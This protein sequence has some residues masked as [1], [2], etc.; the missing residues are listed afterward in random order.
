MHAKGEL[1]EKMKPEA[2][3]VLNAD[4][5]RL[6]ALAERTS[7]QLILFGLSDRAAIRAVAVKE[8]ESGVG[9][10]L[11]LPTDRL[12]IVLKT[13]GIFMV[14]NA[15]AAAAVGHH[16]GLAPAEIKT[17]LE[18]FTP[19]PGR[20]NIITTREDIHIIDDTYNANPGSMEAAIR[21]LASLKG[22]DRGIFVAGDMLELG[23]QADR[24]HK[25]IGALSARC[26][27]ARLYATGEWA[28][29]VAAGARRE[30][31]NPRDIFV[32]SRREILADLKDRLR[33]GDW[34]LVKGSRSM[35]ME[36]I[37]KGLQ[38]WTEENSA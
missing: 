5:P 27:I 29:A 13:P 7:R 24:M 8:Q 38:D 6:M 10:T 20:M 12:P 26:R 37:V 31:M 34:V 35:G 33:A 9:F 18:N 19:V 21:T 11:V 4:D 1:L 3:A 14:S 16:L 15:L 2:T 23:K 17:G 30:N 36:Q 32:G 22:G 25:E 28:A